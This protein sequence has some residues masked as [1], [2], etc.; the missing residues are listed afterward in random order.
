[1]KNSD[2]L[3]SVV[4]DV[5]SGYPALDMSKRDVFLK[6]LI[7]M[8][9]VMVASES[10]LRVAVLHSEGGLRA[11]FE[12]HLEEERGHESWLADDLE[13]AGINVAELPISPEAVAMAGSQYYLIHHV[14]AAALLGYMAVLECF[15]AS[16]E[17]IDAVEAA[18]GEKLCRTLR[19]HAIHDPQHGHH[20]L[21]V[22]DDLPPNRFRLVLENAVQTA[23]YIGAAASK[24]TH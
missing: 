12:S 20:L 15:P 2:R 23:L 22:I 14:D 18:H 3:I 9:S 13:N 8:H 6:N 4:K 7:F 21:Q 5:F 19:Y 16:E 17:A 10:L 11:Y 24:F 1:M